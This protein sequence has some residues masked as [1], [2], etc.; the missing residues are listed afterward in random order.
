MDTVRAVSGCRLTHMY[1]Q[2]QHT[3]AI[4]GEERAW[5]SQF[6]GWGVL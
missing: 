3:L 2:P 1:Y 4:G 6:N 5:K